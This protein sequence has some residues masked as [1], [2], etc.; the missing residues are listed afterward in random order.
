MKI[1]FLGT[2]S[3]ESKNTRLVSFLIDEILA[4]E[5]GNLVSELT[6]QEQKRIKAILLSH[7]HYDHIRGIPSFAFNNTSQITKVFATP[8]TLEVLVSHL[9][10]GIIYPEFNSSSSFLGKPTLELCPMEISKSEI[11]EGYRVLAFPVKHTINTVGFEIS[12]SDGKCIFYT[13]DTGPGLSSVWQHSSPQLLITDLT[14]PNQ[15][16]KTAKESG[17]LCAR[18][19]KQELIEF[20]RLKNYLPRVIPIHLNPHYESEIRGEIKEIAKELQLS[21]TIVSE[22]DE[23]IV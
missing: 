8:E 9:L 15:L 17:N 3:A 16:E 11:I 18:L 10:D 1:K 22:G 2:H 21:I 14:F 13:G 4:V 5:A 23:L 19:L 6:F 7:G 12:S 20:K